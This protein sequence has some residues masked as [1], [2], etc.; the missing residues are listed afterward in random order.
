MTA[1]VPFYE[2]PELLARAL[3]RT[4][5]CPPLE[6]LAATA[7]GDL[8]QAERAPV[9]AHAESCPACG[10]E[11]ALATGFAEESGLSADAVERVV[12]RLRATSPAGGRV[13]AFPAARADGARHAVPRWTRWAAAALVVVGVGF[14]W[15]A[16]RTALPP[17][18][19]GPGGTDVVRGGEIEV[20]APVGEVTGVPAELSWRPVAG[21]VVYRVELLDVAGDPLGGGETAATRFELPASLAEKLRP[22]ARYGWRVTALDAGQ[23][24]LARSA[25]VEIS[26]LPVRP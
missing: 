16:S 18:L 15:Q 11:L 2:N 6:T 9:L 24:E 14:L 17:E 10:A 3:E 13:I 12:E 22:R 5:E 19:A 4:S 26:I 23:H 21:A 7:L 8:P 1:R 25:V 20:E